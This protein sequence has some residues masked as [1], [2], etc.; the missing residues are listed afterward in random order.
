MNTLPA[1]DLDTLTYSEPAP[2]L[3]RSIKI[4][5]HPATARRRQQ[6]VSDSVIIRFNDYSYSPVRGH[7]TRAYRR[8][9]KAGLDKYTARTLI[10]NAVV[11]TTLGQS[12]TSYERSTN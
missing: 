1:P 7:I 10:F 3:R 8:A 12:T 11:A 9:R 6:G 5:H 4:Y 2:T